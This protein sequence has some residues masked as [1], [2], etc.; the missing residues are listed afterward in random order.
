MH[1]YAVKY[2]L[3]YPLSTSEPCREFVYLSANRQPPSQVSYPSIVY[4]PNGNVI[5][6]SFKLSLSNQR[7]TD[8]INVRF[9]IIANHVPY[10]FPSPVK[11]PFLFYRS[12]NNGDFV[13][14]FIGVR[15]QSHTFHMIRL[16]LNHRLDP[17]SYFRGY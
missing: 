1:P 13:W 14:F 4:V 17:T 10:R 8:N 12:T 5:V 7:Y 6:P 9:E 11:F 2:I 16:L 3:H 15:C